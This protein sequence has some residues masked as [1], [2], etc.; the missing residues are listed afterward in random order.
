M[1]DQLSG[2]ANA[3]RAG[4]AL[5]WGSAT[6][7][8]SGPPRARGGDTKAQARFSLVGRGRGD[9]DLPGGRRHTPEPDNHRW[10]PWLTT[11]CCGWPARWGGPV[12]PALGSTASRGSRKLGSCQSGCML[13]APQ[14]EREW[15]AVPLP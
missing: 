9:H 1:S 3:T 11:T 13:S 5:T 10:S 8:G 15:S 14:A 6:S 7:A 2:D 12:T 4:Q